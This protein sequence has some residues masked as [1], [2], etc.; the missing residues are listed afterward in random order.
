VFHI[1]IW[2][3]GALL[4]GRLGDARGVCLTGCPSSNF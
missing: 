1:S 3:L 2:G 4:G